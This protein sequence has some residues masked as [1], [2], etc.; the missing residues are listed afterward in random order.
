ME[1]SPSKRVSI[2]SMLIAD[3]SKNS[4]EMVCFAFTIGKL[5]TLQRLTD[6]IEVQ[7]RKQKLSS[8]LVIGSE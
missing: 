6:L 1:S 4:V 2:L 5:D 3:T 7:P 8:F